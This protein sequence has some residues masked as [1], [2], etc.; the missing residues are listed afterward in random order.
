[1]LAGN[2]RLVGASGNDVLVGGIGDDRMHG[3]GGNDVFTFGENW[4]IDTVVQLADGCVT[5]WFASGN[6]NQWD[7]ANLT[8]A[9]GKNS[10]MVT[11]VT[12]DRVTL[13]FGDD[14]TEEYAT[15]AAAGAFADA[16]SEK[17]FEEKGK[18]ILASL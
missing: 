12:T 4:G 9:D 7:A 14:G 5:L 13:K 2:D 8:Y 15:L 18:G 17:I 1:M 11:G 16:S 10:V 3:G 6:S